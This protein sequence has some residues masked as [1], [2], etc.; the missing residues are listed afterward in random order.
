MNVDAPI[1]LVIGSYRDREGATRDFTTVWGTRADGT[2][3]HTSVAVLTRDAADELQV[4]LSDST[5]KYLMWGGALLGGGV[6]VLAPATGAKLLRASGLSGAG[7]ICSHL[8]TNAAPGSLQDAARLLDASASAL[9]VVAVNRRGTD[10]TALLEHATMTSVVDVV[11]GDLEEELSQDFVRP[12]S[13]A[14]LLA[15]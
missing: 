4:E 5:A 14:V 7:A 11:W 8:R 6:F 13:G 10:M 2:F 3:H 1:S 15:M 12:R 9:V